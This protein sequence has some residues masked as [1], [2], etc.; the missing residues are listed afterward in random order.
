MSGERRVPARPT[1][2]FRS[3][4]QGGFECSTHRRAHDRRRLDMIAASHHDVHAG[5]DY[6]ALAE[7]GLV[8]IR[9]GL[10]WHLIEAVPGRY[11]WSSLEAQL[12]AARA[13]GSEVIWDLLH[14]GWPDHIDV[15]SPDFVT[16]FAA[17]AGAAARHIGPAA[18]G[19][20]RFYAPVNEIS[21]LAWGGGDV[22]YLNPFARNRGFELKVQLARAAIA[23]M[24][25][26]RA[27]DPAA[28]FVYADPIINII[29]D[30]AQPE[31]AADAEGHRL[32]QYQGWDLIAGRLWPQIGGRADLLDIVGVN[33]YHANQWLHRGGTLAFDDPRARPLHAMLVEVHARYGRP[34][35]IAETGIEGE[36]R[37]GWLRMILREVNRAMELGVPV[38]GVCLYP[39]LDHPGWD[40]ERYCPNGLLACSAEAAQRVVHPGLAQVVRE[41]TG[42]PML[43]A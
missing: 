4:L 16:R 43:A 2:L 39:V 30:P 42:L 22:A 14:Y 41:F 13:T 34:L 20:T 5:H 19:Q 12:A 9:D 33:F 15:W 23:A 32:A 24:E 27:V 25:A 35:F 37:A 26:I 6:R 28:R 21:F 36:A 29:A 11:D 8:T 31:L 10:R 18:P 40:D 7:L 1:G 3:F 17:F 38:E